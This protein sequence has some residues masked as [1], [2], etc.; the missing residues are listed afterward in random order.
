MQLLMRLRQLLVYLL[1][2]WGRPGSLLSCAVQEGF[3]ATEVLAKVLRS[4]AGLRTVGGL[5]Q[6]FLLYRSLVS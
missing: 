1:V 5:P 2:C 6:L 3:N 4:C